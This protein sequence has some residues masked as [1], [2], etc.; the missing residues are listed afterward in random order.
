MVKKAIRMPART[1]VMNSGEEGS[2]V[3][4]NLL[5]SN[6]DVK[7]YDAYTGKYVDD[8]FA[9]GII[10]P[11][12]VVKT[13]LQDAASVA[14]MMTTTEAMVVDDPKEKDDGPPMGGGGMGGMGGG[15]GGMGGMM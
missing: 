7:G 15:M 2:V 11:T 13:A 12:L 3:V 5:D 9:E 6:S 1:I 8:M 10:D 4:G 14:G